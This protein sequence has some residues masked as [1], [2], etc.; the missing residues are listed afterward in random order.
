MAP[1][2]KPKPHKPLPNDMDLAAAA[3]F[4][5]VT[6]WSVRAWVKRK[7]LAP[8]SRLDLSSNGQHRNK[9]FLK[10]GTSCPELKIGRPKTAAA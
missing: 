6:H 7:L 3:T 8:E 10:K 2:P 5:G 9:S 1:P 4:W